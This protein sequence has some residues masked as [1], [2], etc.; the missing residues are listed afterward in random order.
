MCVC[1]CVCVRV[2]VTSHAFTHV[3]GLYWCKNTRRK[4]VG[5]GC[6]SHVTSR[7]DVNNSQPACVSVCVSVLVCVCVCVCVS[8]CVCACVF[9]SDTNLEMRRRRQFRHAGPAAA[10]VHVDRL[11]V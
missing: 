8:V 5:C 6:T 2:C 10:A 3:P 11:D 4:V 1:V 9:L 7:T